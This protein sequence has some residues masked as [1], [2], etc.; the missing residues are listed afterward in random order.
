MNCPGGTAPSISNFRILNRSRIARSRFCIRPSV[1]AALVAS[2]L[3]G[4][5]SRFRAPAPSLRR[6][7]V[8]M[9]IR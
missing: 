7:S 6:A 9:E 1:P 3:P 5:D 8:G 2:R 4:V